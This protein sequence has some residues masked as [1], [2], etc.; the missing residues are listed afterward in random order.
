M[1]PTPR[2]FDTFAGFGEFNWE[3][4]L[5]PVGGNLPAESKT[6]SYTDESD[7]IHLSSSSSPAC[8]HV[9]GAKQ[10]PIYDE[11]AQPTQSMGQ[12]EPQSLYLFETH[13][14]NQVNELRSGEGGRI[15]GF[16]DTKLYVLSRPE[17]FLLGAPARGRTFNF[18]PFKSPNDGKDVQLD[19]ETIMLSLVCAESLPPTATWQGDLS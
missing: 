13:A 5:A 18:E 7:V 3:T 12:F 10:T 6:S 11:G 2:N 14:F 16:K 1:R 15:H 17:V 19:S 8:E 4:L 9:D